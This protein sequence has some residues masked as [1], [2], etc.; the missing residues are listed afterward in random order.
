LFLSIFNKWDSHAN[1]LWLGGHIKLWSAKTLGK[2]LTDAGFT[3]T[4]FK[5]CGRTPYFW[6]SMIIKAKLR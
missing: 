1:P 3:V 5:G 2:L 4:N 6:K